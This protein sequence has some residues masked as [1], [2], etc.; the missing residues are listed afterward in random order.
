M[1]KILFVFPNAWDR[2]QLAA[3]RGAW[4][5]HYAVAFTEPTDEDC[6]WDFDIVSF[7]E[8][9]VREHADHISGVSS[10]SDYPGATVAAAIGSRLGLAGSSPERV[11]GCSHKYYSRLAQKSV[12]PE[13]TP[14]FWLLD[15]QDPQTWS[16]VEFPCY[17]KP[18]KGAFSVMSGR[19]NSPEELNEFLARPAVNEFLE[20]YVAIFNQLVTALTDFE[21]NGRYFLAEELFR[22]TQVTLEGFVYRAGT[23]VLGIVDSAT[24][25]ETG[26]FL[27]FDYP[28]RLPVPV[29]DRMADIAA[30]TVAALNL[31][32]TLFN[33]EMI[34]DEVNDRIGIIEVNPRLCGQF[35]DLYQKV[36]GTN[37]YEVALSLAA[38][39][40]PTV[41]KGE[42]AFK[43]AASFPLRIF[44]PS[45]VQRAPTDADIR[46][47]ESES[48]GALIWSECETNQELS[49]FESAEDGKSYR[50]AIVNLGGADPQDLEHS[51]RRLLGRLDFQFVGLHK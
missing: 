15:P 37:G 33:I 4:S 36:D 10:S 35:A 3:C 1:K 46:V 14:R 27:R 21:I 29:Q 9:M 31:E 42:G 47:I 38:G 26:S 5:P 49:D 34:Y 43:V 11:I 20:K 7:I 48:A 32:A 50:Y 18:V 19:L 22:G 40:R 39:E 51:Y 8:Q 12:V 30:R 28:S 41:R 2:K 44:E 17:I 13:A 6:P 23:E 24:H 25:P 45:L 16:K